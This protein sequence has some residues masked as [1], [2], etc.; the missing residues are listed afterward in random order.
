MV[1]LLAEQGNLDR[2]REVVDALP[3]GALNEPTAVLNVAILFLNQG[4]ATEAHRYADRAV[5]IDPTRGESYY[6]RGIASLQMEKMGQAR[7]DFGKVVQLAP[8]SPE[9]ADAKALLAQMN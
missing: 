1:N 6:Y 7:A 4:N 2:A 8:E 5:S 3:A 9:A